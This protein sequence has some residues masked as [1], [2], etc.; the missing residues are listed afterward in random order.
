MYFFKTCYLFW[1]VLSQFRKY[2]GIYLG[3]IDIYTSKRSREHE[4]PFTI[5]YMLAVP[6]QVLKERRDSIRALSSHPQVS[7]HQKTGG[8]SFLILSH[9]HFDMSGKIISAKEIHFPANSS[10]LPL[11]NMLADLV[12]EMN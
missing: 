9:L 8:K 1:G 5:H 6:V 4:Y 12:L 3:F 11:G 10:H 7:S 2:L